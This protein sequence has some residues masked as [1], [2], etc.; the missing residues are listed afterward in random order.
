LGKP[1]DPVLLAL[2]A[3]LDER[4]RKSGGKSIIKRVVARLTAADVDKAV[5]AEVAA[6]KPVKVGRS[7]PAKPLPEAK[8]PRKAAGKGVSGAANGAVEQALEG[9]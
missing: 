1:T 5:V 8:P 7:K 6:L 3:T 4:A 2:I 9:R